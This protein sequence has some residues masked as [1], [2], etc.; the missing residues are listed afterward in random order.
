MGIFKSFPED[1]EVEQSL[2]TMGLEDNG[3]LSLPVFFAAGA[4]FCRD[5]SV[6]ASI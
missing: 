6:K 3:L 5:L 2:R 4:I 1:S